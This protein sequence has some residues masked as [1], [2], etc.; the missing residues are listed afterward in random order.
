MACNVPV[1]GFGRSLL[2]SCSVG[3]V[4]RGLLARARS[5]RAF[6]VPS[7]Q[8]P[9]LLPGESAPGPSALAEK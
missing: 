2:Q 8:V 3:D 1:V 9:G 4:C 6:R 7:A 5:W